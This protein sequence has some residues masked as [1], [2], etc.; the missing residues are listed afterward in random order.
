M[1]AIDEWETS[2]RSFTTPTDEDSGT[3]TASP[4][5]P[6]FVIE[7]S[8]LNNGKRCDGNMRWLKEGDGYASSK[9]QLPLFNKEMFESYVKK[10]TN[11]NN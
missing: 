11:F 5:G 3:R 4:F 1:D 10:I 8:Y 9:H 2:I 6:Y 7:L